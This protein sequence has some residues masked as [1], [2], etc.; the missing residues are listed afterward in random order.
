MNG[1][2]YNALKD[3]V[4]YPY[5]KGNELYRKA[6]LDVGVDIN[7]IEQKLSALCDFLKVEISGLKYVVEKKETG[8]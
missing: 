5:L 2:I 3:G 4:E 7:E 8:K 1:I 6:L